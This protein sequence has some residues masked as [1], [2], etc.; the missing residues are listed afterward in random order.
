MRWHYQ[1][2]VVHDFLPRLSATTGATRAAAPENRVADDVLGEGKYESPGNGIRT[3]RP[4]RLFYDWHDQPFMPVEFS[5]AAY[6]FGHS[7]ARPSYLIK[8]GLRGP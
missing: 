8:D 3:I 6:R 5:V 7:M 1:W 4:R 2:V